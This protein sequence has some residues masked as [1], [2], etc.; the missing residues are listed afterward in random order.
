MDKI[1]ISACL[2]G[3]R[4][5][6]DGTLA[7]FDHDLVGE[8]RA[9]G[10]LVA[11]CPEVAGGLPVPR[12]PAEITRGT[13]AMVLDG[14]GC[15]KS[16]Q[17]KDVTPAF[18]HGA[19]LALW[20]ALSHGISIA[21]L[22]EKSPSCGATRVYDGRFQ[23]K[24]VSGQGVTAALLERNGIRIFSENSIIEIKNYIK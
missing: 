2:A 18:I 10:R 24:L 7:P 8:W 3:D 21:L 9:Q 16:D 22:K 23:G 17:G 1:L 12:P 20:L 14:R 6:Y 11:F 5:R 4:V 15:I 13:G 19:Y